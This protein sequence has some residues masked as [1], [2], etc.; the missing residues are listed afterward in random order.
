M[1][2]LAAR[3]GW[4]AAVVLAVFVAL[5]ALALERAFT[6]S[7]RAAMRERL[8]AQVY[9]LM[10]ATEV[11]AG[12]T[13]R[14][15]AALNE[16]R[17]NLPDSGLYARI[18]AADGTPLWHSPSALAVTLPAVD[19]SG[20]E[21]FGRLA[22]AGAEFFHVGLRIDW[23]TDSGSVP[24]RYGVFEHPAAFDEQM[25][26]YRRSLWGWL[27]AMAVLLLLAL[28][29]ALA[30]GLRPLRTV[31]AELRD[32][33][34]GRQQALQRA[35]PRE[36]RRLS[37]NINTLLQHER[38]QQQRYQ[39]ALADL[40][41]SLKT[42]LAILRG[43]DAGRQAPLLEEQVLRM[44]DIVQHQLQRAATAGVPLLAAPVPLAPLVQR[45]LA[46]LR[47]VYADRAIVLRCA[48]A[49]DVQFRGVEGDVMELL[50]NLLDNACKWCRSQV[51]VSA[52]QQPGM[53]LLRVEDDGAG[54]A[55]AQAAQAVQR[56]RR[57]DEAT[58]GHGIG[59]AMVRDI[60]TAYGGTLEIGRSALGG[61]AI[62][63]TLPG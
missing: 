10:A 19:G 63:V 47:K 48:V 20:R 36:I 8:L 60:V 14:L 51:R 31:A 33:E 15:P 17:L 49:D 21:Q 13:P 11:A 18:D 30:W 4:S 6:D 55:A 7:A 25:R 3:V 26:R 12:G 40:A 35:Y 22:L 62:H 53:L 59:L 54:I 37:D 45:L 56:G 43:I 58:P 57:L 52:Q 61:A 24:L 50:G 1:N 46:A 9:L 16:P 42:P 38:A 41:H 29:A 44:D 27:A 39:H 23:E 5:T 34:A 2:S 28:A 32:I